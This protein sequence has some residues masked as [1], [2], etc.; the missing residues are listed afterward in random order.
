[1]TSTCDTCGWP[2]RDLPT[3]STHYTSQ[4][5]L[6]YRRCV[7]GAW[8][9]LLNGQPVRAAPVVSERHGECPADA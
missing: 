7:C 6:R 2:A 3:V 1:M 8:L 5:V 9:V 4:G